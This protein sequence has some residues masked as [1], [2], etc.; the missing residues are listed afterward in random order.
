[1]RHNLVNE[2]NAGNLILESLGSGIPALTEN[3]ASMLKES[4][5]WCLTKCEHSNGVIIKS[6]F[7]DRSDCYRVIWDE[8]NINLDNILRAYNSDDAIEFGA[9]AIAFLLIKE[10]T[11]EHTLY[12]AIERAVKGTGIDY[13]L[14]YKSDNPNILFSKTDARLEITGIL[15]ERGTNTIKDRIKRK[16]KQT[17]ASDHTFPVYISVIEFSGPK[18]EMIMKNANN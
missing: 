17:E 13:W 11:L 8:D 9:E 10:H 6:F 4:C 18:A 5:I 14:G 7:C 12:T 2:N 15:K 3:K 16:M 1:M